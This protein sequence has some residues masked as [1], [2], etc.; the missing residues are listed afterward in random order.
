MKTDK[1]S[2]YVAY[3]PSI[4]QMGKDDISSVLTGQFLKAF[5]KILS[6]IDDGEGIKGIEKILDNIHDYFDPAKTPPEFLEWLSSWVA[7]TLKEGEGWS[8]DKKRELIS[9]IIPLYLKRGTK[10]GLEEYLKIYVGGS[11]TIT[12]EM[13]PFRVGSRIGIDTVLGGL[14]PYLFIV[15]I[16]SS[17]SDPKARSDTE[18]AIREIIDQ[19]KPAHT[20]YVIRFNVST[21]Q[22]G[23][24]RVEIN[25]LLW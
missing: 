3:L 18:K 21:M 20:H 2:K 17:A 13:A 7:L 4:Y 19:E 15:D 16:M 5:E 24:S 25:T 11:I 12:E 9:K 1:E 10:E 8:E 23:F 14:P 22:V 6:G